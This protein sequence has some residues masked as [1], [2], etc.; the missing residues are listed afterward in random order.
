MYL[1]ALLPKPFIIKIL[2][3]PTITYLNVDKNINFIIYTPVFV[4]FIVLT[5]IDV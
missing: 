1:V 3:V 2:K 5:P 4:V